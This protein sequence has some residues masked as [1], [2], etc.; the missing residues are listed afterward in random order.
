MRPVPLFRFFCLLLAAPS[1][2][3]GQAAPAATESL[4]AT[5]QYRGGKPLVGV[6]L[7]LQPSGRVTMTDSKGA[8]R[9]AGLPPGAYTV[10]LA[11]PGYPSLA[12]PVTLAGPDNRLDVTLEKSGA[13][14]TVFHS[15]AGN[16]FKLTLPPVPLTP[17][18]TEYLLTP[19]VPP[20]SGPAWRTSQENALRE[21][22][23]RYLFAA[24]PP[25]D[26]PVPKVYYLSVQGF[27]WEQGTEGSKDPN[28]AFL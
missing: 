5:V 8:A 9:F 27:P 14:T 3:P 18:P 7:T 4:A 28:A 17:R 13:A 15:A 22:T 24:F 16:D 6:W 21:A 20:G 11:P 12:A 19:P 23:F 10:S 2:F 26:T 25:D 1:L